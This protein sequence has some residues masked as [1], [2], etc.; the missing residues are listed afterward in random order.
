MLDELKNLEYHGGKDGLLFFICDV[1]GC[2]GITACD[3]EIIC[4]HAPGKRLLSV[5]DLVNYCVA[6]GWI[7]IESDFLR[8]SPP[9]TAF[10]NDKNALN[11]KLIQ[12]TVEH[13]FESEIFNSCL[14]S[15]DVVQSCY[16]FKNELLPLS[17]SAV[18]N[19]LISQGFL[20]AERGIQGTRFY[21]MPIY[22]SI[23]AKHCK[24]KRKQVTIEQLKKQLEAN[25]LAGEKAELFVLS[26]EKTRIGCPLCAGIKRISEIDTSA[27][28]DIVSF[29][30]LQSR[31]PDRFI[32]VKA[33]SSA[34]FFWSKNEYEMAKLKGE[35]YYL[36]L[37]ELSHINEPG[38]A[39]EMIQ[40]PA[41]N[42]MNSD[43][44]FV[45]AQ[46]YHIKRVES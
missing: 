22:D 41:S 10:I 14:F 44:W 24:S 7:K 1:I 30:S 46:S 34:G 5:A 9:L 12:S 35:K 20:V 43:S 29:D 19:V 16:S 32:E 3:A 37:V 31:V 8:I 13:L 36:Y 42:V 11:E 6:F 33:V 15:Y 39:P 17:F 18:R 38:Y 28:Y 21:I 2:N 40:N 4:S 23:V 26:F 45:E 27:G 25:E